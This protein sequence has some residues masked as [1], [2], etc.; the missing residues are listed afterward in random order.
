MDRII[1]GD[2]QFFGVNHLSEE[3]AR[4]QSNKFKDINKIIEILE[5]V[6]EIGIKSFM[7]TTYSQVDA[8][9]QHFSDKN[10]YRF[11]PEKNATNFLDVSIY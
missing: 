3:K 8:I 2:N 7:V 9:C 11:L 6:N 1:F 5:Y 4:L 10:K